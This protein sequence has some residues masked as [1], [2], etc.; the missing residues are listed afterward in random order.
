MSKRHTKYLLAMKHNDEGNAIRNK[1][2]K[3]SEKMYKR[4]PLTIQ[5]EIKECNGISGTIKDKVTYYL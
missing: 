4:R 1:D 5:K 2:W 3:S